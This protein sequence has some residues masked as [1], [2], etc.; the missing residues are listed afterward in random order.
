[1]FDFIIMGTSCQQDGATFKN[2]ASLIQDGHI[3]CYIFEGLPDTLHQKMAVAQKR[4]VKGGSYF[5]QYEARRLF[6][7]TIL[8]PTKLP[9]VEWLK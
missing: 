7:V 4:R 2:S 1:M 5:W 6:Q 9:S 3:T 8:N